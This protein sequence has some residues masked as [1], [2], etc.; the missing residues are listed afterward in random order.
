[1]SRPA[2]SGWHWRIWAAEGAGTALM[3]VGG[4]SAVCLTFGS[5]SPL[6]EAL[7][8]DSV[9]RLVV[10][11]LFA[12]CVSLVAVSP[13][14]RLSGAHLNPAVTLSFRVLGRVSGHDVGGYLA[15]QAIG[16]VVGTEVVRL[17]WGSTAQSVGGGATLVGTGIGLAILL[18]AL[19]TAALIAVILLFVSDRRLAPWTPLAIWP[20]ITALVWIGAPYTGTSLNPARSVAP[21]VV[22]SQLAD[23]WVYVVAPTAG[24][25]ALAALWRRRDRAFHPKTAKLFHDPGYRCCLGS[26][27]PAMPVG[28][29]G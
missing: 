3:M 22:F 4:L 7:P 8:S 9:R 1:V 6:A 21:A 14:G 26:D 23:L 28:Q 20:A 16:A 13:L 29:G 27:L 12:A 18:E 2:H 10:G 25:V 17:L 11:A 5:G 15:V 19:M 24:A